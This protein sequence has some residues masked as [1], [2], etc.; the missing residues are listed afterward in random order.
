MATQNIYLPVPVKDETLYQE[1]YV[2]NVS[3]GEYLNIYA[4]EIQGKKD[5]AWELIWATHQ[6]TC[7]AVV[8][9]RNLSWN[10][11]PEKAA[12]CDRIFSMDGP[13]AAANETKYL[14]V[15]LF[16]FLNGTGVGYAQQMAGGIIGLS[17]P[18]VVKPGIYMNIYIGNAG[19]GDYFSSI[20]Q[21]KH[22]GRGE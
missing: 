14:H 2:P 12:V 22:I 17:R 9:D 11:M 1:F 3:N 8:K 7:S 13:T 6:L 10:L 15:G 19:A 18:I 21:F 16:T 5:H 4:Q 20:L